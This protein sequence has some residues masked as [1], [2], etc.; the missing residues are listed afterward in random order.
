MLVTYDSGN[1]PIFYK[2]TNVSAYKPS[3]S[4]W[5]KG[6]K[7]WTTK[8]KSVS[9]TQG[10]FAIILSYTQNVYGRKLILTVKMFKPYHKINLKTFLRMEIL[11]KIKI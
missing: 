10:K 2:P 6:V 4:Y 1:E 11:K 8:H 7:E 9:L 3:K 5:K